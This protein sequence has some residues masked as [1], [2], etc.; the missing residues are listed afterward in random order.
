M[1]DIN[2]GNLG[3]GLLL[4]HGPQS[5]EAREGNI[6]EWERNFDLIK[7]K[8]TSIWMS[9]HFCLGPADVLECLTS[10]PFLAR[11]FPELFF[12]PSVGFHGYRNPA[13]TAKIGATFQF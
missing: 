1:S 11:P 4:P 10:P 12:C 9:Y 3:F 13:L 6:R 8:V 2:S 5:P 7:D